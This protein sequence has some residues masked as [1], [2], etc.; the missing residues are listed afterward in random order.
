MGLFLLIASLQITEIFRPGDRKPGQQWIEVQ[1]I[2]DEPVNLNHAV[3][4]RLDGKKQEQAWVLEISAEDAWLNPDQYGLIAQRKDLGRNLCSD[5]LVIETQNKDFKLESSR[6]QTVCLKAA[7]LEETC[8]PFSN[9]K[10]MK[11]G[12]S[13]NLENGTWDNET[14]EITSGFNA[15]PGLPADFC[16]SDISSPWHECPPDESE[17]QMSKA[18]ELSGGCRQVGADYGIGW[19][20][21]GVIRF[22]LSCWR[23]PASW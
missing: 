2:G 6:V 20:L 11:A 22:I 16:E 18:R 17:A 19:L 9:S 4:R 13:R 1:N 7:G 14:C 8:A 10:S 15:S 5:V 3:I 12:T 21:L 23:R